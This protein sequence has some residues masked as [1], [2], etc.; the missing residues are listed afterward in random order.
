MNT[1]KVSK[2]IKESIINVIQEENT[3]EKITAGNIDEILS[4]VVSGCV[5]FIGTAFLAA[6][7]GDPVSMVAETLRDAA[8]QLEGERR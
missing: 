8:N 3:E 4:V 2:R 1:Q 7:F 6:G 5:S